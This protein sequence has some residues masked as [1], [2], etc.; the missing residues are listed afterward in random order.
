MSPMTLLSPLPAFPYRD[1]LLINIY[2][3][4][5][6]RDEI[7]GKRKLTKRKSAFLDSSSLARLQL[8]DNKRP[9][10]ALLVAK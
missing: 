8:I 9:P 7:A 4:T 3:K 1:N 10:S 6:L 2:K 5:Q